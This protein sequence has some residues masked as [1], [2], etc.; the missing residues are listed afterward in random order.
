VSKGTYRIAKGKSV[1]GVVLAL[2]LAGLLLAVAACED[3]TPATSTSVAAVVE[4]TATAAV[5]TEES[6]ATTAESTATTVTETTAVSEPP[7]LNLDNSDNGREVV[8]HVGERM[9]IDLTPKALDR[10]Q[11]VKWNYEPIVVQEK[12]SG[13][14]KANDAVVGAWLEVEAV[15]AG[16]VTIR[17]TY[18]YPQGTVKT[19]WTV[20]VTVVG[21][22]TTEAT[23]EP[24]ALSLDNSDNG[25]ELA[26]HVGERVRIDLAPKVV[27]QVQ[28]VKWTWDPVVM[29]EKDSGA[30]KI[31]D[32]VVGAWLELE[33]VAAGPVTIRATYEYPEGAVV[34]E[35]H[36][37]LVV[38]D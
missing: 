27:D 29:Q 14:D 16:P 34:T 3:A 5:T 30:D 35:W 1:M 32:V 25:R 38:S 2:V 21:T 13:A 12:D 22:A 36:V 15:V 9:R 23:G 24:P 8:L 10:V 4:T 7:A 28:A 26:L 33:A 37:F 20:Y 18:E 19:T 11:S 6:T 31:T 17:A